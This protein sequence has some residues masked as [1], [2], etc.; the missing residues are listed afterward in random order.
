MPTG[1]NIDRAFNKHAIAGIF[2]AVAVLAASM[3]A[4]AQTKPSCPFRKLYPDIL[5]MQPAENWN[6][7]DAADRLHG[8]F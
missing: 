2:A 6:G 1:T 5:M 3:Q 7:D 8:S 4:A